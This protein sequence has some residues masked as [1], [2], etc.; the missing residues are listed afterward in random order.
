MRGNTKYKLNADQ[1]QLPLPLSRPSTWKR[2]QTINLEDKKNF[3]KATNYLKMKEDHCYSNA[4]LAK[5]TATGISKRSMKSLA[6]KGKGT[7]L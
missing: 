4:V 6:R 7:K 5:D 2:V 1:V 3:V